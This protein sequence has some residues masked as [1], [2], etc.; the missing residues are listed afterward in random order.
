MS[1]VDQRYA[2]RLRMR[3]WHCYAPGEVLT[4]MVEPGL[5]L[6]GQ[7]PAPDRVTLHLRPAVPCG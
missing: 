2:E 5:S 3:G 6:P 7:H 4:V 1:V